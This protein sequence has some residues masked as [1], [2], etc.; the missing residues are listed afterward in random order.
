ML[1]IFNKWYRRYLFEEE[2]VLLLVLLT[3][4]VLLLMTIGDILTPV[5]AAIVLAYLMQGLASRLQRHG[6]P[7]GVGVAIAYLVFV[8]VFFGVSLGVMPLVWRQMMS[9]AGETPR[10][11]DLL[12][13]FLSVL[14][15]R[16]PEILTAQQ[17]NDLV[18][19]AQT[20]LAVKHS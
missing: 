10:M 2:S 12:R 11:L 5:L 3:L 20:E 15:E 17:L 19:M 16:Y 8:G 7:Q 4:G 1:E 6:L 13:T 9:L 14:P 18:S